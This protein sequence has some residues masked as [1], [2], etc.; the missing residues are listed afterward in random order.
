MF[1]GLI[2][3]YPDSISVVLIN[4]VYAKIGFMAHGDAESGG[5]KIEF[6][7]S[8]IIRLKR[9]KTLVK[10]VKGRKVKHGILTRATVTKNHLSPSEVSLHQLD[11]EITASGARISLEQSEDDSED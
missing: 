9:I 1:V 5:K 2:N 6:H 7:S 3:K 4:Q 10:T 8:L 11:F